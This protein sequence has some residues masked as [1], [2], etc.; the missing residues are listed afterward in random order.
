MENYPKPIKKKC[1]EKILYQMNNTVYKIK[2]KNEK[3]KYCFFCSIKNKNKNIPVIIVN[4]SSSADNNNK[5]IQIITNNRAKQIKIGKARYIN[6]DLNISIIEVEDND[7]N[8]INFI[9]IDDNLYE[10]DFKECYYKESIYIFQYDN[11]NDISVSYGVIKN[12]KS[13]QLFYSANVNNNNFN[14]HGYPIFNLTTNK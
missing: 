14:H 4:N 2:E 1:I 3:N 6:K 12:I 13:S 9:E 7:I 11:E 5:S 8:E 10:K